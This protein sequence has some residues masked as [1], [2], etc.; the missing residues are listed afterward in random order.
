M[1]KTPCWSNSTSLCGGNGFETFW[2]GTFFTGLWVGWGTYVCKGVDRV[3]G[4]G[5]WAAVSVNPATLS[6]TSLS[7]SYKLPL[8]SLPFSLSLP[9]LQTSPLPVPLPP[10]LRATSSPSPGPPNLPLPHTSL[11]KR[12]TLN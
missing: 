6:P 1:S 9:E 5:A 2:V 7:Q 8:P 10:S 4:K 3:V 11:I 12:R